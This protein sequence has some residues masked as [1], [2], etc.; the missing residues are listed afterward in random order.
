MSKFTFLRKIVNAR[1]KL[2]SI[3]IF[4]WLF[5]T[6]IV[7]AQQSF[8]V[9]GT[10]TDENGT[11]PG[12]SIRVKGTTTG[13]IS[14]PNGRYLLTVPDA[15]AIL[16]FSFVGY[17]SYEITV[18]FLREINVILVEDSQQ[19]EEVVVV[20]YGVQKKATLTGAIVNLNPEELLKTPTTSLSNAL[21]GR[22]PGFSSIQYSGLPGYDDPMIFVRGIGTLTTGGSTPLILVDGVERSFSQIDPN[23]VA[24][25]SILKDASATAV[26]GV[27]GAN[28]VILVTTKRGEAG[29]AKITASGSVGIQQPTT[30]PYFA[31]SYT[32]ATLYNNAQLGDG[33]DPR[34]LKYGSEA[35]EMWRTMKDPILYP[36]IDWMSYVMEKHAMQ[37]Q[38]NV[39]VSGGNETA[40]YFVSFGKL[41]QDGLFKTFGTDPRNNFRYNRYNFRTN[42]D[43]NLSKSTILSLNVGGR[44]EDRNT[45]GDNG[46]N[47]Q[48]RES[49]IFVNLTN[50]QP[51]AGAGIID[52]KRIRRNP[53]Y[54]GAT[55]G[56][57]GL[58]AHYGRGFRTEVTNVLNLDLQLVQKLNIVTRGLSFKVKGSYN[59]Y[60]V[61]NKNFTT[62]GFPSYMP[63]KINEQPDGSY[64]IGYE[65]Q[66]DD[67]GLLMDYSENTRFWRDWY[68]ETSFD[69]QNKF[70]DHS[71]TALVL[72]NQT[73]KYYPNNNTDI[74]TGYVGLV[75][76]ITYDYA[77]RY[78]L[79]LNM[80]YNGS[81]NFAPGKRYG[82]FPSV[83]AGWIISSEDFLKSQNFLDY[84]KIRYSFGL[85]G[86]DRIGNNRFL[87]MPPA[88]EPGVPSVW[89]IGEN[90]PG[91]N[92][93]T[94]D[95]WQSGVREARLG[96]PDVTWE[97][98]KKQNIG[99]DIKLLKNR[100]GINVDVFKE[101]RRDILIPSDN[102]LPRYMGL[103]NAPPINYGKVDNQGYEIVLSWSDKI[104][105][106]ISYTISPNMSFHR[107]KI[108]EQA[109][110]KQNYDYLYRTGHKVSQPFGYEF[111]GFYEGPETI[112]A[113]ED[114]YY[115]PVKDIGR[116]PNH[117]VTLQPGD[118]VY[119]DLNKDG[120]ID[121]QD[122]H[123]IGYPD[124]PEYSF[125]LTI[126]FKIKRFDFSMLWVG[127]TNCNRGL[128]ESFRR[129][130]PFGMRNEG[131]LLQYV[132]DRSWTPETAKTAS[133]P[134]ITFA[135]AENN[136]IPDQ[137]SSVYLIDSSYARLKNMEIA[138]NFKFSSMPWLG[139]VRLYATGY[140]LLTFTS[141]KA[142]DPENTGDIYGVNF[143]YPQT[144]VYN[145]GLSVSF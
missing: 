11:L 65:K 134:R 51:M 142:N 13:V 80:G 91:Y 136:F 75:G 70:G 60:F 34:E 88:F 92:F 47:A 33:V 87:Y 31:N 86:S 55:S 100:F 139:N 97:K 56:S 58:D 2:T 121:G 68:F 66:G 49:S 120:R 125:G 119:V 6:T 29:K 96:N 23:E 135:N 108:I 32:Y 35:I 19:I 24:D 43:V 4:V 128:S 111:F 74:P 99:V 82:F 26:F 107:N 44:I 41:F 129:P 7:F 77:M 40:K 95:S 1:K 131:A 109:E 78:L 104:G 50:S 53:V 52:G 36:S 18:G 144:R 63:W 106:D 61:N 54:V 116:F 46:N 38:F 12:V 130:T 117:G 118:C 126:S 141:F 71:I 122:H 93:G 124:Y 115:D 37:H 114:I 133:L 138:Y 14:D 123:A 132:A 20:G 140:N 73:K 145:I 48:N 57:D 15:D 28:G 42:V 62:G 10:V 102:L 72:Y 76:R 5:S 103:P 83:S 67:W 17:T 25:V 113:Y 110:V 101:N 85:V 16:V 59:N 143:R 105:N 30:L 90:R 127:A 45:T 94:G 137:W 22:L 27:R 8:T 84:L 39:N 69:Y 64:E 79:D 3:C 112:K 98:S 9:S 81:E 21:A 89:S